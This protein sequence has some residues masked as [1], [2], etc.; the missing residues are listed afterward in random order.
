MIFVF[1]VMSVLIAVNIVFGTR[2]SMSIA[3]IMLTGF[4]IYLLRN[5]KYGLNK[6]IK[7]ILFLL[8]IG[9][10]STFVQ[11]LLF[12]YNFSPW[13]LVRSHVWPFIS[14][15]LL[16]ISIKYMYENDISEKVVDIISI[17]IILLSLV[18]LIE[19]L[20]N[21]PI[22]P[23]YLRRSFGEEQRLYAIGKEFVIPFIPIFLKRNKIISIIS[24]LIVLGVTGGKSD[25]MLILFMF[26]IY[27]MLNGVKYKELLY[28]IAISIIVIFLF[29]TSITRM[30]LLIE[31]EEN[32]RRVIQ[33]K[34]AID[35]WTKDIYTIFFGIGYGTPFSQG[36]YGLILGELNPEYYSLYQNSMYDV[37]NGIMFWLM[38]S[39]LI[40]FILFLF[41][42][43]NSIKGQYK[44]YFWAIVA[45]YWMTT[46]GVGTNGALTFLAIGLAAGYYKKY[47]D[48]NNKEKELFAL[49]IN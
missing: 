13:Q 23:A 6:D 42:I 11:V 26:C 9:V 46:S 43:V 19:I 35:S 27:Y 4:F 44:Y 16:L 12:G 30:Q 38:R 36:Y 33:V 5:S 17:Y 2:G 39:G 25:L 21:L 14:I 29:E 20:F 37:E 1:V 40:G 31:N 28:V 47:F 48:N 34:D 22:T 8:Y 45:V 15:V 49:K 18:V 41:I 10:L 7:G 3:G 24:G 32:I